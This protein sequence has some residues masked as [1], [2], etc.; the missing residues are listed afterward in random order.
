MILK[1]DYIFPC[2]TICGPLTNTHCSKDISAEYWAKSELHRQYSEDIQRVTT[3][4][5]KKKLRECNIAFNNIFVGAMHRTI[6]MTCI[7]CK[8]RD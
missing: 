4:K 2:Y 8:S 3:S 6:Y 7:S 5:P 1:A